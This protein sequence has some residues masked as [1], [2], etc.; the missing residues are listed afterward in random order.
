MKNTNRKHI[1]FSVPEGNECEPNPCGPYTGCRIIENKPACFCLPNYEGNPPRQPCR[2]P[3]N[4]CNPSPC[5]PNTQCTVLSNGFSKCTCLQGYVESPNT[6]RGCIE[7]RNPC[8]PNTCGIGARCD[9]NRTPACYC[10][11]NT[12]GNP[13]KSCK[14]ESYLPPSVLCQPGNCGENA[15]C[16]VSNNREMCF[17]KNGF[18]GDPYIGCQPQ[19]SPCNPNPCGPQSLCN[20]NYDGQALCT[21]A[22]GST[23]DPY[24]LEGCY[25]RECEI[26][27]ECALDKACIGYACRDPCPGL[28]GLNAKCHVESH[29]PVCVCEDGLIGNPLVCCL[30]P[31]EQKSSR[32]CSKIQCGLNAICQDVDNKALCSCLPDFYGDPTKECKP[33]CLMNSDCSPHEACINRKCTDP[34]QQSNIC[35]LNAVCLCSDH[36]VS[37]LC[38]DGY[39]GDPLIQCIYRRKC[40][41]KICC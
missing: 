15:D 23:G 19:K 32:P 22:E 6:V 20:A 29:H 31:E 8:E 2:L 28:C 10:P 9:P 21:C 27:A 12:R 16:Y 37:C 18:I 14:H 33:E 39:M 41:D 5:G 3:S 11:E 25:S 17:C 4:P 30:E 13:Y 36:T 40:K 38:P 34:C 35:G 7:A 24:S 26:D 1:F